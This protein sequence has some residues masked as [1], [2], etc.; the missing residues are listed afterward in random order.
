M[1]TTFIDF[2]EKVLGLQEENPAR[3]VEVIEALLK[4]YKQAKFKKEYDKVDMIRAD[5]KQSGIILKDMKTG[6]EWAYE[7]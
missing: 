7:E 6:V 1:C 3:P 4:V 2:T 5:L